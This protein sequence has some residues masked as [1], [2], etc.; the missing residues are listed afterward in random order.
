MLISPRYLKV[1]VDKKNLKKNT[2]LNE[3]FY[4]TS[5]KLTFI[6]LFNLPT[7]DILVFVMEEIPSSSSSINMFAA[8]RDFF[9]KSRVSLLM[10]EA[11]PKITDFSKFL[12]SSS[13][14]K[15]NGFDMVSFC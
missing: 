3:L 5:E 8:A 6:F 13:S 11:P 4:K 1:K 14:L 9:M 12:D 7:D 2:L 15:S 10:G